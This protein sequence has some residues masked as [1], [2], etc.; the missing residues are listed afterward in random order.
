MG[1]N[2]VTRQEADAV[3]VAMDDSTIKALTVISGILLELPM[4]K[5]RALISFLLS[6]VVE[7]D[8]RPSAPAI[9]L[10]LRD[11]GPTGA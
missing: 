6:T 1:I 3:S 9:P 10:R 11:G 7:E 8:A 4:G 5:R 2:G